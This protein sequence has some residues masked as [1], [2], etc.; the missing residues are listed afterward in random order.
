MGTPKRS[1]L[2][3]ASSRA[4]RRT[5]RSRPFRAPRRS[6]SESLPRRTRGESRP[7]ARARRSQAPRRRR[8]PRS[9]DMDA[10]ATATVVWLETPREADVR[11]LDSWARARGMHVVT[12]GSARAPVV[13]PELAVGNEVEAALERARDAIAA[14]EPEHAERALA[15]AGAL[16]HA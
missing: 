10:A 16:L 8:P 12:A 6:A 3:C 4:Q 11:T 2:F 1:W 15:A 5:P 7:S 13:T 9:V 14:Q